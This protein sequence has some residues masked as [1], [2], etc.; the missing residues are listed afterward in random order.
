MFCALTTALLF[1][2][3]LLQV[4]EVLVQ[5]DLQQ[6][7]VATCP[8]SFEGADL[9]WP[10]WVSQLLNM[11]PPATPAFSELLLLPALHVGTERVFV[12]F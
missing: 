12:F 4:T 10:I 2:S 9:L 6:I 1:P 5:C 8:I 11:L 7:L 3:F